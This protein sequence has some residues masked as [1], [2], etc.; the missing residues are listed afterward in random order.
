ML[1]QQKRLLQ[2]PSLAKI[3]KDFYGCRI[4]EDCFIL[5][6]SYHKNVL[7]CCWVWR[8][9]YVSRSATRCP[10]SHFTMC[11]TVCVTYIP[12]NYHNHNCT[13]PKPLTTLRPIRYV[14]H[15]LRH[16]YVSR[17]RSVT[18]FVAF[19]R[20]KRKCCVKPKTF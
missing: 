12:Y 4:R 18:C 14:C 7:K 2:S 1:F 11:Y 8:C 16:K 6:W 20:E 13:H 17:W 5:W 15:V 9:V 10:H 19:T 3:R